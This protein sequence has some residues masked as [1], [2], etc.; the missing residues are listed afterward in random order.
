MLSKTE[1]YNYRKIEELKHQMRV[2]RT[3]D[4]ERCYLEN[5]LNQRF[6]FYFVFAGAAG[7]A[8]TSVRG[9]PWVFLLYFLSA[10]AEGQG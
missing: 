9:E 7:T 4:E 6:N 5:L 8:L 10:A 2:E 3:A 1:K